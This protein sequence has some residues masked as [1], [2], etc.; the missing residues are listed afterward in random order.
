M[1]AGTLPRAAALA[2]VTADFRPCPH[3]FHSP[4]KSE[5]P[6]VLHRM[7]GQWSA[8]ERALQ[9][10][11][12]VSRPDRQHAELPARIARCSTPHREESGGGTASKALRA[13]AQPAVNERELLA[14][15][16]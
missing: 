6:N 9:P 13:A 2:A 3:D 16:A 1:H 5:D 4:A 12:F 7:P 8:A 14:R 15:G 10:R 11:H